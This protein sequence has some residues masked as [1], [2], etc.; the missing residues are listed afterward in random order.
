MV[1][2]DRILSHRAWRVTRRPGGHLTIGRLSWRLLAHCEERAER[3]DFAGAANDFIRAN[4]LAE[5][6][7]STDGFDE[8]VIEGE[9]EETRRF[10][11][12]LAF[13]FE[14]IRYFII[15]SCRYVNV[16]S[17]AHHLRGP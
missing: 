2:G 7:I 16:W 8:I 10:G 17:L 6:T 4:G 3:A 13:P 1:N 11:A 9:Y 15:V 5:A 14:R 12:V